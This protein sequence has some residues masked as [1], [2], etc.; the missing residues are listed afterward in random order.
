[1][2]KNARSK[3]TPTC[4]GGSM[5]RPG[6]SRRA[7]LSTLAAIAVAP[8]VLAKTAPAPAPVRLAAINHT[9]LRASDPQRSVEFF[10]GLFGMPIMGD[11]DDRTNLRIADGPAYLSILK[12]PSDNPGWGEVG[13]AVDPIDPLNPFDPVSFADV[14]RAHGMTEADNPGPGQF[15][16]SMRGP[17]GGGDP[18]GT[19]ELRIVDP[20]GLVYVLVHKTHCGGSGRL[21]NACALTYP[22]DGLLKIVEINHA[23]LGVTNTNRAREF[24]Q[25]KFELPIVAYQGNTTPVYRVAGYSS[26]VLFDFSNDDNFKGLTPRMD[27][28]CYALADYNFNVVRQ[29]LTEYGLEDLGDVFRAKGP[30]QHYHTSRRPDRGGAPGGSFE[31]YFTDPDGTVFQVQDVNYC[32]GGGTNGEICGTPEAPSK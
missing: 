24:Y 30:L 32:G 14:L 10:Q 19:P 1:M 27:H 5:F 21:G 11:Y 2:A 22:T 6:M 15:S 26:L 8:R 23:T 20:D 3:V 13:L 17:D 31:I 18:D 28:T 9:V 7:F 29:K 4:S 16:L 12:E 25:S